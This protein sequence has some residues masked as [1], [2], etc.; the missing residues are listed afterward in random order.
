MKKRLLL[1]ENFCD[2]KRKCEVYQSK[3]EDIE[4][5]Q[6]SL[7]STGNPKGTVLNHKNL[8]ANIEVMIERAKITPNH[9]M[10]SW[11]PLTLLT[12]PFIKRMWRI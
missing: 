10:M 2:M 5:V 9:K 7:G 1:T 11:M 8:L 4:F 3:P 12:I 6:F